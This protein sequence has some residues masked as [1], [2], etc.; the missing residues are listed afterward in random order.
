MAEEPAAKR[1]RTMA[2]LPR[3]W[4]GTWN[5]Y[6]QADIDRFRDWCTAN[7]SYSICGREV[8]DSGTPHLQSFHQQAPLSFAKFKTLF[9]AIHVVPVGKDNGCRKYC[10]KEG[11][12]A[13]ET[14]TYT[15][16]TPGRRTDLEAVAELVKSG[17]SMATIAT[18]Y[19][20]QVIQYGQGIQRLQSAL[21]QPRQP[22][23]P[24]TVKVFYGPTG[25]GKTWTAFHELDNPYI[26]SPSMNSWWD[27]YTG[28]KHVIMDEFRGQLPL[29][30]MLRLTDHFPVRVQ[31]K[32]GS[33]EFCADTIIITSPMHPK[34]WYVN[35]EN[36]KID[37]L[38][39]RISD[40][41]HMTD[42]YC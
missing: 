31:N 11:N 17:A 6:S 41:Y 5:N 21:V 16:K 9:P 36:D 28:Q 25:T 14:G 1:A 29:G 20:T 15:E 10:A 8:G 22:G 19:P 32:G 30:V 40:I 4:I 18:E 12:L 3:Q 37:Q 34:D 24:V 23:S 13:F 26:W 2:K 35:Q 42:R 33:C 27:G 39:R 38:L 7:T